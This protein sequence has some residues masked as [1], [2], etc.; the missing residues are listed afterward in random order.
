MGTFERRIDVCVDVCS[1]RWDGFCCILVVERGAV[2]VGWLVGS[3]LLQWCYFLL[4]II[5]DVRR[6]GGVVVS[7]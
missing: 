1:N 2:C 5:V 6:G 4:H 7:G 3:G